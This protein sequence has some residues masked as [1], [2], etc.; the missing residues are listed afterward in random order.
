MVTFLP[1]IILLSHCLVVMTTKKSNTTDWSTGCDAAD[2][3]KNGGTC[4]F[5]ICLCADAFYG[6]RCEYESPGTGCSNNDDCNYNG[7]CISGFCSCDDGYHGN[8]CE[9]ITHHDK[10]EPSTTEANLVYVD[11]SYTTRVIIVASVV[12]LLSVFGVCL[13]C[14]CVAIRSN[15]PNEQQQLQRTNR[16]QIRGRRPGDERRYSYRPAWFQPFESRRL[17]NLSTNTLQLPDGRRVH[18]PRY[19]DGNSFDGD[20]NSLSPYLPNPDEP[21]D[22]SRVT[23]RQCSVPETPP[24]TYEAALTFKFRDSPQTYIVIEELP[25]HDN[26]EV[27]YPNENTNTTEQEVERTRDET[28]V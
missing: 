4:V 2:G 22:Y 3:C 18:I 20:P 25:E 21:P 12:S 24:P 17:S 8:F 1:S 16:P 9:L 11:E 10:K 28:N 14:V 26:D 27:F 6:F 13:C 5:N 19:P 7:I 23:Q 15:D